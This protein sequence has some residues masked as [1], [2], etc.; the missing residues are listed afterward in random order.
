MSEATAAVVRKALL[1]S[2]WD[3]ALCD[4]YAAAATRA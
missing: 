4:R 1:D 2:L 3:S